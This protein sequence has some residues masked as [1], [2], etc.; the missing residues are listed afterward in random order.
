MIA[1]ESKIAMAVTLFLSTLPRQIARV[2]IPVG[3]GD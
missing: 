2:A 3:S 1:S